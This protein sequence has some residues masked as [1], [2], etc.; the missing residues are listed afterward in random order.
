MLQYRQELHKADV[1][2]GYSWMHNAGP[3]AA[4]NRGLRLASGSLLAFLDSDDTWRPTFLSALVSVLL[5]EP[6]AGV[7]FC[8]SE[9]VDA[10]GRTIARRATGLPGLP[11]VGLLATPL[12]SFIRHVPL[13]TPAAL[14]RREAIDAAGG[15]DE[16]F[17]VGEDWDLWYRLAR[18]CDF[19]YTLDALAC[20]AEHDGNT[21]QHTAAALAD[22]LKL[23][24]KHL[25]GVTD[26][27]TQALLRRRAG[28]Y[29]A[30][31]QERMLR[32]GKCDRRFGD[33]LTHPLT[34][35]TWRFR[36]ASLLRR[37]KWLGHV[38][39]ECVRFVGETR[40]AGAG[41]AA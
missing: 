19:A 13:V 17:R 2:V 24:L 40:R 16:S 33:L 23:A 36:V 15:F 25:P 7:A 5:N 30:L 39:A 14:A 41:A 29:A 35:R 3:A 6:A 28:R 11:K 37:P 27:Q 38:Y 10:A 32:D 1:A 34:P 8:A 26:P 18:R 20:C 21:P 9:T 12:A 4:R 22:K 31:L